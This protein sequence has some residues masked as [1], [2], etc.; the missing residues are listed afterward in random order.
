MRHAQ[1]GPTII[2]VLA[3][4]TSLILRIGKGKSLRDY[5]NKAE[6]A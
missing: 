3:I 1:K 6:K 5:L 4:L 2:K